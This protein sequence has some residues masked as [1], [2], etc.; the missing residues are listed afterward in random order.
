MKP[1]DVLDAG[2]G[3]PR[4]RG[5]GPVQNGLR[6]W[7]GS[8][9]SDRRGQI[10]RPKVL[11]TMAVLDMSAVIGCG[12]A[13]RALT[14][15]MEG[16][17]MVGW[18]LVVCAVAYVVVLQQMWAYTIRSFSEPI[19]QVGRVMKAGAIVFGAL[20]AEAHF[21]GA[22][23][24]DRHWLAIWATLA[25]AVVTL[26]RVLA[27]QALAHLAKEGRLA[28]R[29]VIVGGGEAAEAVIARLTGSGRDVDGIRVLGVFDDRRDV[30]SPDSLAGFPKIGTFEDLTVFVR[31]E[32]VDLLIV[33]VP[34]AA[35]Y[36]LQQILHK[37]FEL[38]VDVRL[39]AMSSQ[40][41]L[42][43][44]A[45]TRIGGVPMLPVFNRPLSDWDRMLK[46]TFDRVVGLL[47]LVAFAPVMAMVA[48]AVKLD[49]K[50]PVFFRQ[51]RH[52]FNNEL[53]DVWKFRSM[54][55]EMTD[56]SAAT[57]ATRDDPRVTP[58]GRFIRR[59]SLDELPQLFNV[60][61]RRPSR[62]SGHAPCHPRQGRHRALSIRR[63]SL[64]RAPQ[65]QAGHHRLGS[66]QW[67]A[68]RDR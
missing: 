22:D 58:V 67:L 38:P 27:G 46:T 11:A 4:Q 49:S 19:K 60:V 62:W 57:L 18:A 30:R 17:M 16:G 33:T 59:T 15:G 64:L 24:L 20:A 34:M 29:T 5:D 36:R 31:D 55:T 21:A 32:G 13:A 45:Y 25:L 42:D 44:S 48:V 23:W 6:G 7:L 26:G 1:T 28:R 68:G 3:L 66:G 43:T 65:R 54:Y 35:E 61:T 53:I 2:T 8:L 50:G 37:L 47:L 14:S 9:Y 52:G 12:L 40:L 10:S 51:K 39:S 56:H 63:A 41:R